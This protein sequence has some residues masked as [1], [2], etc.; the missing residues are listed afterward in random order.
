M[1][2]KLISF[3]LAA[4]IVL[5]VMPLVVSAEEPVTVTA[6]K[7]A[8]GCTTITDAD[9]LA[10]VEQN[11]EAVKSVTVA[12][13]VITVKADID[14]M[15]AYTANLK[16][17]KWFP[18]VV[19]FPEGV[20]SQI[21]TDGDSVFA[22]VDVD[23]VEAFGGTDGTDV[24]LWARATNDAG[25]LY[26]NAALPIK[27][28]DGSDLGTFGLKVEQY[29]PTGIEVSGIKKAAG[30]THITG[31]EKT[32]VDTNLEAVKSVTLDD[33]VITVV[34]K[35]D[36]MIPYN[37]NSKNMAWFPLVI[38]FTDE[39]GNG[40]VNYIK[41][42]GVLEAVDV[43]DVAK[44]GGTEGKDSVLWARATMD[45]GTTL[46]DDTLTFTAKD[47]TTTIEVDLKVVEFKALVSEEKDTTKDENVVITEAEGVKIA[48]SAAIA[49]GKDDASAMKA[50]DVIELFETPTAGYA[51]KVIDKDG[52]EIEEAALATTVVG[53]GA[54]VQLVDGDGN[55]VD[56]VVIVMPGDV[57]GNGMVR[58]EDIVQIAAVMKGDATL[59]GAFKLAA[60]VQGESDVID[61]A[62]IMMVAEMIK[63]A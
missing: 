12:D 57:L 41:T 1:K 29:V 35:T 42:G 28:A 25:A 48:T 55:V 17:M 5:S 44:F 27:K 47:N 30:Y 22:Q 37:A 38:S 56:S 19:T 33:G 16:E 4:L 49:A 46:Y 34:A 52:D 15:V 11:L 13:G 10:K 9:E 20:V 39:D 63:A 23:D 58:I 45:D 3:I 53:T 2:K 14:S 21:K 62:D 24:I 8:T 36:D 59:E 31:D 18:L 61:I 50:E 54:E 7:K 26:N 32:K 60:N 6:V 40:A 43:A 51:I